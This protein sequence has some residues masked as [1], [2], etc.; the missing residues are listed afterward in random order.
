MRFLFSI[1]PAA[2]HLQPL[3]PVGRELQRRGHEV[4]VVCSRSFCGVAEGFGF[5]AIPAGLDWLR[6]EAEAYFPELRQLPPQQRYA[7]ILSN[8]YSRDAARCLI[9]ELHNLCTTWRPD[10]V[11]RDQ[12]EFA[13]WL[14]AEKLN[15]PQASYGY[16]LGF[17]PEDQNVVRSQLTELRRELRLP[18][19]DNLTTIFR[20]L[21]LEFAPRSYL[22]TGIPRN[23]DT[24][25]IRAQI[26]DCPNGTPSPTWISFLGR[27]PVVVATLGNTYNRTPGI[28]EAIIAALA[29]E[30]LDLVLMIGRNRKR[31]EFGKLPANVRVEQYVPLS[32][33][34]PHADVTICHAGFNTIFSAVAAGTPLVLIPIDSD[35]PAGALRCAKLG[36]GLMLDSRG[37]GP[38]AVRNAVS[39]ALAEPRYRHAVDAFRHELN[40][41][42]GAA[43]AASL[44]ESIA[45]EGV[46]AA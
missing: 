27:R 2:S 25:H 17:L 24:H 28:F 34:L 41:L 13:S 45:I 4:A 21:R 10:V 40:A 23:G 35:Q 29:D 1:Q 37:L 38:D 44:L 42:P 9:P 6:A 43:H 26:A 11:I 32:L 5:K 19:D 46:A 7:W 8:I 16:G 14:V 22:G 30:P 31:E 33:L 20:H 39:V 15:I 18:P 12:M 3:V 36:L